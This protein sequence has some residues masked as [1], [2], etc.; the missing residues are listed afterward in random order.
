MEALG[1][2][3][4]PSEASSISA[5]TE[6]IPY[7]DGDEKKRMMK[8]KEKVGEGSQSEQP[9][10]G[11]RLLLDLKLSNDDDPK[12][13]LNLLNS[14]KVGSSSS[15]GA[16]A[17]DETMREKQGE[18]PRV[19]SCNFCKREF[20][21]SQ[22]LGGHQNAHKQERALAK[23]RQGLDVGAFGHPQ[24]HYYHPY[25]SIQG[26][27]LYGSFNRSLGVRMESMIHKPSYPWSP[28][29]PGYRLGGHGGWSRPSIM[30]PP[31]PSI[32]RLNVEGFQMT[33]NG[34]FGVPP[35]PS[36]FEGSGGLVHN[37]GGSSA[38]AATNAA[39]NRETGGDR[40]LWRGGRPDGDRPEG[41][42]IDLSLK[43]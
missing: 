19:F 9:T 8:M 14:L 21:T 7:K 30:N 28:S 5:A 27:P 15:H 24:F 11:S 4:C 23:R 20:S 6:E 43:L 35:G 33:H 18:P 13:E 3:P 1:A 32:D 12:L 41:Q 31:Q 39:A 26:V 37:F 38:L 42:D 22:A 40:F 2:E 25:S 16:E 10:S 34:R 17:S 29:S 36:R